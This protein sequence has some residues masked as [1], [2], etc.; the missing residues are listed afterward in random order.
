MAARKPIT[1]PAL[2]PL[3]E[4]NVIVRRTMQ[5]QTPGPRGGFPPFRVPNIPPHP[6]RGE[7]WLPWYVAIAHL[8]LAACR[9]RYSVC[10]RMWDDCTEY[11]VSEGDGSPP[12]VRVVA[13]Q[14]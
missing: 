1:M 3:E 2:S 11:L 7:S 4:T 9:I 12:V 10:R 13:G 5:L 14:L 6:T 8:E